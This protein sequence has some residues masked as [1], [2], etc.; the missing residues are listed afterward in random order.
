MG[1]AGV[2][3]PKVYSYPNHNPR[4]YTER[5]KRRHANRSE[6]EKNRAEKSWETDRSK[7]QSRYQKMLGRNVGKG[8]F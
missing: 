1:G 3:N 8:D 2:S 4:P 6:G 5:G 7:N